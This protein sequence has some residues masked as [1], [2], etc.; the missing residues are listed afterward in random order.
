MYRS[1]GDFHHQKRYYTNNEVAN[2]LKLVHVFIR[3]IIN[4]C[5]EVQC[6]V[7]SSSF[8]NPAC[9]TVKYGHESC[10]AQNQE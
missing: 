9:E 5:M 2:K 6:M 3:A 10:G 1:G 8:D 4:V 7:I